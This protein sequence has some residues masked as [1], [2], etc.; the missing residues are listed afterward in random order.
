[1]SSEHKHK[2]SKENPPL[3]TRNGITLPLSETAFGKTSNQKGKA[4]YTILGTSTTL[5]DIRKFVGE[6]IELAQWNRFFRRIGADIFTSDKNTVDGVISWPD[7]LEDWAEFDTG[8]STLA[9]LMKDADLLVDSNNALMESDGYQLQ[10]DSNGEPL[11]GEDGRGIPVDPAE[12]NSIHAQIQSNIARQR[13][14]K[15]DIAGIRAKYEKR[16]EKRQAS[17]EPKVPAAA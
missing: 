9:D 3:V 7:I 13:K 8:G 12:W 15:L 10:V 16:A 1:M 5:A 6:S 2:Y 11:I 4:F 14:I 17:T